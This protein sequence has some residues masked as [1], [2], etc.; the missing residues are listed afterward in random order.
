VNFISEYVQ[1]SRRSSD[2]VGSVN[3]TWHRVDEGCI[4]D[5]S[6][7]QS[8]TLPT[9]NTEPSPRTGSTV[10]FLFVAWCRLNCHF[11]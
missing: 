1:T 2:N 7:I 6:G 3:G 11:S 4:V 9:L 8:L 10:T 5:V